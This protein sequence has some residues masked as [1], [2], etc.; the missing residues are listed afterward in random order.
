MNVDLHRLFSPEPAVAANTHGAACPECLATT[1]NPFPIPNHRADFHIYECTACGRVWPLS[2]L[3]PPA[4]DP[5][6]DSDNF[7]RHDRGDAVESDSQFLVATYRND[8]PVWR[9]PLCWRLRSALRGMGATIGESRRLL[10]TSRGLLLNSREIEDTRI[11]RAGNSS[12]SSDAI[13]QQASVCNVP[14]GHISY[15]D[16]VKPGT[17]HS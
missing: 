11:V 3:R 17:A 8:H 13:C 2:A 4:G 16:A 5:H 6:G 12:P 7:R 9:S 1:L 10:L 15:T 14:V